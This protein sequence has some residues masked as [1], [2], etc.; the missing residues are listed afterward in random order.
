MGEEK[1]KNIKG[2]RIQ[3]VNFF[4]IGLSCVLYIMLLAAT[5]SVSTQYKDVHLSMDDFAAC[6]RDSTLLRE[7]SAYLTEQV[8][9][10]TMTADPQYMEN[11]FQEA[12]VSR[13][14]EQ[15]LASLGENHSSEAAYDYLVAALDHSNE[16]MKP[17]IQAMRLILEVN[18]GLEDAPSQ[19][20]EVQLSVEEQGL[21]PEE[22]TER[23]QELVFGTDYQTAKE[24]IEENLEHSLSSIHEETHLRMINSAQKL[25]KTMSRQRF[26]ITALFIET[27]VTFVMI[28]LLIVKPLQI[29]VKCIREDKLMEIVGSYEFKYL[30]LTYN[31]IYEVNMANENM[32]RYQAEHDPL[33]GLINRNAFDQIKQLLH[34]RP[35]PVA[36]LLVDV[37]N[38]KQVNDG[39]GHDMGDKVLKEVAGLLAE[40]FRNTDYPARIGGDEFA[41]ILPDMIQEQKDLVADKIADINAS[42]TH[43]DQGFPSVSLSVGGAF[44]PQGFTD[45][46]YKK[47]DLALYEV[48]EN[49]RCGCRFYGEKDSED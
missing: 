10:Y 19:V 35:G 24:T 38:F 34:A 23:A 14:R 11:Y 8:R 40:N 25:E 42:L 4:M 32:L 48:K 9:L 49:G 43:P 31:D 21:S 30:A 37:D 12:L 17:E 28:I 3:T 22:M 7:G 46:L 13:R 1:Q 44:S 33:T 5:I 39:W 29:Y 45:D 16:L 15:A 6:E 47:A 2:I 27:I 20:R 36:L 18:G 26:L 41:V